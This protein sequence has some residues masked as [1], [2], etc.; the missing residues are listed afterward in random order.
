M[1]AGTV[2]L[3]TVVTLLLALVLCAGAIDRKAAGRRP[4][5]EA[6]RGVAGAVAAVSGALGLDRAE[7]ALAGAADPLLGHTRAAGGASSADLAA[8]ARAVNGAAPDPE[9][10]RAGAGAGPPGLQP[11]IPAPT[12]PPAAPPVDRTPRLRAPTPDR[13]LRLWVGGDSISQELGLGLSQLAGQTRLFDVGRDP[14]A[15]TGLTR[16]DYF[17]WP[18]HLARDVAPVAGGRAGPDVVVLMFGGNDDQNLPAWNGE[19]A[20][21]AGSPAWLDQ[22]RRRVADTMDLLKSP[23][24]DR[25]VIWPGIP[26][27]EPGTLPHV[28]AIN[29]VYASE[30]ARRP[31]VRYFDSTAFLTDPFGRYTPTLA[32]A[33]G[34]T[35]TMRATDGIHLTTVGGLRLAHA[36]YARLATLVDLR[37]APL[38]ADPAQAPP[39]DVAE[40]SLDAVLAG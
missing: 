27:G 2:L 13:P 17:N 3:T 16:P 38:V 1:P 26:V 39:P 9:A 8:G 14:R 15:S 40:R 32:N 36:L 24:D 34:R 37:A 10:I 30:A 29:A 28:A 11:T 33:D 25:L 31:W 19:P 12:T 18:E 21:T 35:R 20:Q 6:R 22:Y 7:E 5:S 4:N 23:T